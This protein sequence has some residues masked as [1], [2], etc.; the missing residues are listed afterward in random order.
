MNTFGLPTVDNGFVL[1][2]RQLGSSVPTEVFIQIYF[3][4]IEFALNH[5]PDSV[6]HHVTPL[7][8]TLL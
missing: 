6:N 4:L 5:E 1:F 3:M 7:Q 2:R 8:L